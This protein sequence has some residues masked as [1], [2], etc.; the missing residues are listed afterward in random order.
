MDVI[1]IYL[2]VVTQLFLGINHPENTKSAEVPVDAGEKSENIQ[3]NAEIDVSEISKDGSETRDASSNEAG[4][5]RPGDE[6]DE[7]A[8]TKAAKSSD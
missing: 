4:V 7:V 3:V 6:S 2:F 8:S 5:K 1:F